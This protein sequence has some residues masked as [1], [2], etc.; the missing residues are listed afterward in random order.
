MRRWRE[1]QREPREEIVLVGFCGGRGRIEVE[2]RPQRED[3]PHQRE[4]VRR[5]YVAFMPGRCKRSEASKDRAICGR[6][7]KSGKLVRRC[8]RRHIAWGAGT[9]YTASTYASRRDD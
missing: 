4:L 1:P 6:T 7:S 3:H 9:T 2:Q 8:R 5:G